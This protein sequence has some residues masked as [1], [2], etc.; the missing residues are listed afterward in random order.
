MPAP[1]NAWTASSTQA[2]PAQKFVMTAMKTEAAIEYADQLLYEH[3]GRHLSDLQ[4]SIIQESWQGRTYG[5]VANS[6]GYSEGHIKDVASQLWKVLSE[7]LG[8]RITKG[9]LRSRLINRLKR[10]VKS[11]VKSATPTSLHPFMSHSAARMSAAMSLDTTALQPAEAI[12]AEAIAAEAIAASRFDSGFIGRQEALRSL[13]HLAQN[14][15]IIV[16][17]GE[18]GIG[19]TTLAQQY[20]QRF[21]HVLELLMAKES[22]NITPV[23]SVVE[24]WLKQHFNEEPGREFGVTLSRLKQH[25]QANTPENATSRCILIDNL[26]PALDGNGQFIAGHR[27]YVELLRVLAMAK[28]PVV[29]TSRDRLCEPSVKVHHYRLPGL[30]Y[31]AWQQFFE[32]HYERHQLVFES[33]FESVLEPALE[34]GLEPADAE[35]AQANRQQD[36]LRKMHRAYGGNAKAMEILCAAT[37]GD[38]EGDLGAYWQENKADLLGP[39]DVRNLVTSQVTRLQQLDAA[40]YRVFC[41]L[42]CYRYQDQSRLPSDAITALMWDIDASQHRQTLNSLRDRS[43]L[44]CHKGAYWLHPVSRAEAIARLRQ[45]DGWQQANQAAAHYWTGRISTII[46][47][48]DGLQ[49]LEAFYHLLAAEDYEGA[50]GVLLQSRHNQWRQFLPLASSL[51]RMGLLQPVINAITQVL[52][53]ITRGRSELNN[54]LGDVYWIT[55]EIHSA[56]ACQQQTLAD[57]AERLQQFS[58]ATE[59]EP[60][61]LTSDQQNPDQNKEHKQCE[62]PSRA[63]DAYY[64]KMLTVDAHLSIGLYCIDLWELTQAAEQFEQVIALAKGSAHQAWA[65]KACVGLALVRAYLGQTETAMTLANSVYEQFT[66]G[67]DDEHGRYA[68]FLQLLGQAFCDLGELEKAQALYERAIASAEAGHYVQVQAKA[69]TGMAVLQRQNGNE[70]GAIVLHSQAIELCKTIGATCDLAEAYFQQGLSLSTAECSSN[71]PNTPQLATCFAEA[72]RLFVKI[73]APRQLE[74]VSLLTT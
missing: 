20:C 74:R 55:G 10:T 39:A 40:A 26:E 35:A 17:K 52:P 13:Q 61:A 59:S 49:A 2:T 64:L 53:R 71:G 11:T 73:R 48:E 41:R 4:S 38:F 68:Y 18:G 43:L 46:S 66:T 29:M 14:H 54:I 72:N 5:Q 57:T 58:V 27:H 37:V 7:A 51:Y 12:A 15:P 47:V 16:I 19:K 36:I 23:E 3:T 65:D 28:V 67:P 69:L 45:H 6:A 30:A 24:E 70:R 60:H 31:D 62:L 1:A 22:A 9:N 50:A 8:E 42:G 21:D 56:I 63:R 44:E 25:L 34:P 33:A 32:T